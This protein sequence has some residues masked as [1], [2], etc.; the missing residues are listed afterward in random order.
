MGACGCG[1]FYPDFIL[2]GPN[3]LRYAIQFV[4]PCRYCGGLLGFVLTKIK[5]DEYDDWNVKNCYEPEYQKVDKNMEDFHVPL[6]SPEILKKELKKW[7]NEVEEPLNK[8]D[9]GLMIDECFE[10]CLFR[11]E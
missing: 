4:K 2:P 9:I 10:N 7:C 5:I 6:F 1:D 3:N 8:D 11:F